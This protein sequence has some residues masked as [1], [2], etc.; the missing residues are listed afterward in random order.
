MLLG[1]QSCSLFYSGSVSLD[2]A[3]WL[4][5]L[6]QFRSRP[7][8]DWD[9][10]T[11][12]EVNKKTDWSDNYLPPNIIKVA[13]QKPTSSQKPTYFKKALNE[14]CFYKFYENLVFLRG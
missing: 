10:T 9:S 7:D 2:V 1:L 4:Y 8:S 13:L 6:Q 12:N 11:R 3:W 14:V 5:I